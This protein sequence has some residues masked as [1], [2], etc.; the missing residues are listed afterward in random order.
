MKTTKIILFTALLLSINV[1]FSQNKLIKRADKQYFRYNYLK[2]INYYEAVKNKNIEIERILA[3]C[4]EMSDQLDKAKSQY[5]SIVS[6]PDKTFDDEWRYFLVLLKLENY[7]KAIELLDPLSELKFYDTRI[8][9]YLASGKFYEKIKSSEPAFEIKNLKINNKEQ[10]FGT[11]FYKN[12]VIFASSRNY[13]KLIL[14]I[15]N[16]NRLHFLNIYKSQIDSENEL[17][18]QK[19]FYKKLNKKYHDGPVSFNEEGTLMA[20]T[21]DNYNSKSADGTR[22]IQIFTS[23]LVNNK[24]TVPESFPYNN[25]EY[26][27]GQASL[28]PDGRFMY[29]ASDMPG[30]KGGTDIYKVEKRKDGTWGKLINIEEINTE[31][32]EMFPYYHPSG[33]LFFSSNGQVGLGGLDLFMTTVKND[34]YG[35]VKNLGIPLNSSADDFA[36]C[37]DSSLQKGYFSSNRKDGKGSDDIYFVKALKPLKKGKMIKGV[38][39]DKADNIVAS[40]EV[41]L[42]LDKVV[43]DSVISDSLGRYEFIVDKETLYHLTGNKEGYI[44]GENTAN[45][46]VPEDIIYADLVLDKVPHF[47]LSILVTDKE[48]EKPIDSVKITL[49]NNL[50]NEEEI[51][52]T[53]VDGTHY[54]ELPDKKLNDRI[55]YNLKLDKVGYFSKTL[56][57]NQVLDREG[58]FKIHEKLNT[59]MKELKIGD[60]L[61]T[62]FEINP[63]YF[64][65]DKYNIRPDAALELDKIVVIMN[66]YPT[67][68]IELGSHTDCRAS[69]AYNI[70]LSDNRAKSSAAYIKQR[71]SNP[72]RI[73]GKGYGESKLVNGCACEGNVKSDCSEEEHQRNRRTEFRIIKK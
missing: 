21:R 40:A 11:V 32:D 34:K 55:S 2:A 6:K 44:G 43:V 15:W 61:A 35:V 7:D 28:T 29:F 70:K 69:Y 58:N 10:D 59:T 52:Y 31:G 26:S 12:E 16:G 1:C 23:E 24:W 18:K 36:L 33:I 53:A 19:P 8:Q 65:L 30:G 25:P 27:I 13:E 63:I 45:T 54:R 50:S 5:E 73:Y 37:L 38:S 46:N 67:M 68:V 4:Y 49:S 48:T 41:K 14:R 22:K 17:S 72:E 60:D 71:I 66:Q 39:K 64:D 3:D 20:I 42:I 62:I 51:I 57:Y 56:T 47:S 9:K